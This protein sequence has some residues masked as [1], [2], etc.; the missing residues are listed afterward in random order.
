MIFSPLDHCFQWFFDSLGVIQ[1][2]VSMVFNGHGPLV[3]RCDGFD[4]SFSSILYQDWQQRSVNS[5]ARTEC[6]EGNP[7]GLSYTG[8][9]DVTTTGIPCRV[10]DNSELQ[11]HQG[12]EHKHCRN[13]DHDPDGVCCNTNDQYET[14]GYCSIPICGNPIRM[15]VFDFS[16]HAVVDDYD[17]EYTKATLGAGSHPESVTICSPFMMWD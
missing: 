2:L 11:V 9:A 6:Q 15:K 4:G 12:V 17:A 13:P 7:L 3:Q 16:D 1:P 10:W 14:W 5:P 8:S